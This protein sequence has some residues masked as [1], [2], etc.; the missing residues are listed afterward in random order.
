MN[1]TVNGKRMFASPG[2]E[3]MA[4]LTLRLHGNPGDPVPAFSMGK[5]G[6]VCRTIEEGGRQIRRRE[7]DGLVVPEKAGNAAGGKEATHD[8]VA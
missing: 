1:I 8:S 6:E 4:C 5:V 7:S 2:S 3:T